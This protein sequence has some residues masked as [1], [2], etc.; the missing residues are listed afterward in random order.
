MAY[1][2][3]YEITNPLSTIAKAHFVHWFVGNQLDS[4]IWTLTNFS[5]SGSGSMIDDID[6]GYSITAGGGSGTTNLAFNDKRQF[7]NT[8]SVIIWTGR[9]SGGWAGFGM[10]NVAN[11]NFGTDSIR[12]ESGTS[13]KI[14]FVTGS[15][16]QGSSISTS[17]D[18]DL[19]ESWQTYKCEQK[20][21]S[22]DGYINGTLE[23]T[24]TAN[25]S[26]A[27]MQPMAYAYG[28]E[29]TYVK[30]CEAYNT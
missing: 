30:Y 25:L 27:K 19:M 26:R 20:A 1:G 21:A 24:T 10:A 3:F 14:V 18:F 12:M 29:T 28:G 13:G 6:D 15:S 23:A 4:K 8:G 16:S 2:S 7:S 5:G 11:S 9:K 22:A 17:L